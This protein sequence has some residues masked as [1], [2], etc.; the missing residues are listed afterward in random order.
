MIGYH[1]NYIKKGELGEFSKIEEE[2]NEFIDA[3]HQKAIVM[4]FLE[5]SDLL[6][7]VI[8]YYRKRNQDTRWINVHEVLM[9]ENDNK[10]YTYEML[11]EKYNV[12]NKLK[13]NLTDIANFMLAIH[14]YLKNYNLKYEDI[15]NMHIITER[16]F[17]NNVR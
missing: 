3:Y 5:L 6:G 14:H 16:V 4:C 13:P 10:K 17:I 8:A 7:A 11:I 1:L 9:K 15:Y 2:F 12:I